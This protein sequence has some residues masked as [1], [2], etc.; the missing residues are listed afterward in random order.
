VRPGAQVRLAVAEDLEGLVALC[1]AART[2]SPAS[3]D[4]R[5]TDAEVLRDQFATLLVT[6]GTKVLV[7]VLD[8]DVAG[9]LLARVVERGPFTPDITLH[10]EALYVADSARRRGL[11]HALLAGACAA[12]EQAGAA[13][14]FAMHLPGA[15]GVQRFFVRMGFAP[16]AAHR[17]VATQTLQRRLAGE[18]A[19]T[20]FRKRG[21]TRGLEDLIARRRQVRI[22]TETG[23]LDL[24]DVRAVLDAEAAAADAGDTAAGQTAGRESISM[25]VKRAVASRRDSESSTTIS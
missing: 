20:G 10:V 25:H 13:Q 24:R 19:N 8:D 6:P 21:A 22:E 11:G 17:V 5:G 9:L 1:L 3:P 15:R 16:A 7:G 2:E 23:P 18:P 14:V 4:P 12:A